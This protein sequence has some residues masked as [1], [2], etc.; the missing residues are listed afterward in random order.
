MLSHRFLS[1]D[2]KV[3]ETEFD[4]GWIVTVNFSDNDFNYKGLILPS[5]GYFASDK[6]QSVYRIK[7]NQGIVAA[8]ELVDRV[9]V[10]SYNSSVSI[11]GV[12]TDG[13]FLMRKT[14]SFLTGI[15]IGN[16]TYVDIN[17]A[18][19]PWPIAL[20][21][22]EGLYS[23]KNASVKTMG[24]GWVRIYKTG[25]EIF[26]KITDS[27]NTDVKV[28]KNQPLNFELSQNFPNPF[29]PST[30]IRFCIPNPARVSI[31]IFDILG[32]EVK[33]LLNGFTDTG[34][35][36]VNFD[37]SYLPSGVYYYKISTAGFSK[38]KKMV[39]IR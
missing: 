19:I 12:K 25:D 9:F 39:L 34:F 21:H 32:R 14:G 37:A 10:K 23:R 35:H 24:N 11:A 18:E 26:Y 13:A 15:F 38:T 28:I 29:N 33:S 30:T 17:P 7:N 8:A 22:A 3:Q 5:K 6:K 2:K 27:S 16:Q 1:S 31:K 20:I 36:N 4:N